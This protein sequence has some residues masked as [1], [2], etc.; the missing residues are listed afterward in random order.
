M[1]GRKNLLFLTW[2]PLPQ[3]KLFARLYQLLSDRCLQSFLFARF[4]KPVGAALRWYVARFIGIACRL[5][6]H[7]RAHPDMALSRCR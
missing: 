6:A 3:K 1:A 5:N 2:A 7:V 4:D